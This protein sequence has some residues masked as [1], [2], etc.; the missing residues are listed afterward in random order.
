MK[1]SKRK[2]VSLLILGMVSALSQVGALA[3]QAAADDGKQFQKGELNFSPFGTYVDQAGGKWGAGAALTY[4][5]TDKIGVG[6]AT[7][8]TE[9][10]GTAFDNAEAEGYFR[11]P[12]FKRIAPYA[13]GS[14]GYQ[15]D[16]EYWFETLGAGVDFRAFKRLDAFADAQY[17]FSDSGSKS[18]DGAFVRLGVRMSF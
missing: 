12:L 10:G 14:I 16:R 8:W 11:L 6:A 13:V 5:L 18:G 4:F 15:F 9:L 1:T 2:V 17:R 3:Q 7:Y